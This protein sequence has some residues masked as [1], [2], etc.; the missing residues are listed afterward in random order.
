MKTIFLIDDD[1]IYVFL[2]RKI[3]SSASSTSEIIEFSDGQVAINHLVKI[4]EDVGLLP[5]IILLDLSMPVMDGWGFLQEYALLRPRMQKKITLFIVSSSISPY[6]IARSKSFKEVSDFL[7]K[8]L[9][10]EKVMEIVYNL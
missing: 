3:L 7:I 8:P 2:T 10:K 5:D 6:E 4:A 1:P 9:E